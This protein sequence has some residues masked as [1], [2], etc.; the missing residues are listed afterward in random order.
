MLLFFRTLQRVK[1]SQKNDFSESQIISFKNI[2]ENISSK[3]NYQ[4]KLHMSNTSGILNYPDAQ[5]DMVRSGIGLYGFS[6]IPEEQKNF[7]T[8][9]NIKIGNFTNTYC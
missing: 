8:N 1:I 3:L 2:A 5:F 6:N 9:C 7:S 4:P